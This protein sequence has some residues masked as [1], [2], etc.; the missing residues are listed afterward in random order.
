[1]NNNEQQI[2]A[3][4][5][6]VDESNKIKVL[7]IMPESAGDI[8]LATSLL[9]SLKEMYNDAEIYFACKEEYFDILKNNPYVYKVIP[10]NSIMENQILMEG[11]GEWKGIG[12]ISIR[13]PVFT[14]RYLNYLNNGIGR[15]AFN[16]RK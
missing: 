3:L 8:F 6:M 12:D 1:M 7:F 14:Q 13:A 11:T 5:R 9:E 16:I 10:Y 15:I 4:L 2:E